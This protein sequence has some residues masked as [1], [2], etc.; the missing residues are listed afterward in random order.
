[1]G[2]R[3][4][5]LS[6][7]AELLSGRVSPTVWCEISPAEG[8]A[9]N[10]LDPAGQKVTEIGTFGAWLSHLLVLLHTSLLV[11][12]ISRDQPVARRS[13]ICFVRI[14]SCANIR[15]DWFGTSWNTLIVTSNEVVVATEPHGESEE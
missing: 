9:R 7:F 15:R 2:I 11:A 1:M 6:A 4:I 14:V 10:A 13:K 3:T 5:R 8:C 12:S